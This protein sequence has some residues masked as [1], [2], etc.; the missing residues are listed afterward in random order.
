MKIN[1]FIILATLCSLPTYATPEYRVDVLSRTFFL[2][3]LERSDSYY[4]EFDPETVTS[5]PSFNESYEKYQTQ[6][7]H[8][9]GRAKIN[10][11]LNLESTAYLVGKLHTNVDNPDGMDTIYVL[12]NKDDSFAKLTGAIEIMPTQSSKL[13]YGYM[14]LDLELLESGDIKTA[15]IT[16]LAAS[17][18]YQTDLVTFDLTRA[19]HSASATNQDYDSYGK[20]DTQGNIVRRAPVDVAQIAFSDGQLSG[21][22]SYGRQKGLRYYRLAQLEYK[23]RL[24]PALSIEG[25]VQYRERKTIDN[26]GTEL[27][28]N[29]YAAR[30]GASYQFLRTGFAYSYTNDKDDIEM[31]TRWQNQQGQACGSCGFYVAGYSDISLF[32]HAGESA[33]KWNIGADLSQWIP[34]LN[35]DGYLIYAYD[36]HSPQKQ[37]N[38]LDKLDNRQREYGLKASYALGESG[39]EITLQHARNKLTN[40]SRG[41]Y[42]PGEGYEFG[43]VRTSYQTR[44][45]VN[46]PFNLF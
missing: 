4:N 15:P 17:I 7:F 36:M 20:T 5:Y 37:Q 43:N 13:R 25:G 29:H 12:H 3:S 40:Y 34:G 8:I 11:Y 10:D 44:L 23:T 39:G 19:T 1:P 28:N 32:H 14:P 2:N 46:Y 22:A 24:T 18:Q 27:E 6:A 35:V 30:A 42:G 21:L 26:Y 31:S 9:F 41:L 33:Y 38:D 16:F 45:V